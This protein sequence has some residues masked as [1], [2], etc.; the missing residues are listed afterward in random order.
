MPIKA[1]NA[2][3]AG[4]AASISAGIIWAADHGAKVIS[5]SAAT[6]SASTTLGAAV[7]Y[8]WSKGCVIV[9]AAGNDASTALQYPA[10]YP[11]VLSVAATDNTDTLLFYSEYGSWIKCAAPG[12]NV[13]STYY[14][15]SY[16]GMSGTSTAAPH[17]AA[18]AAALLSQNPLLSNAQVGTL[19]TSQVDPVTP[20]QGRGL[21][22]GVGRINVYRAILAAGTGQPTLT[23]VSF[24][25]ATIPNATNTLGTVFLG[26]PAPAGGVAVSLVSS[27][28]SVATVPASVTVP[29]GMNSVSFI[30]TGKLVASTSKTTVKATAAGLIAT[31]VLQVNG[32]V[33]ASLTISPTYVASKSSFTG[34]ITLDAPAPS[35][36][37]SVTLT[38]N[39]GSI[40]TTPTSVNVPAGA[41]SV[42][43]TGSTGLVSR[44]TSVSV[45][46]SRNGAIKTTTIIVNPP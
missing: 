2:S 30:A 18:E 19:I 31:T 43:F 25:P 5:I 21:A 34:T 46:A 39:G 1:L 14:A 17:V 45:T 40:V 20:Y 24:D 8:A 11:N 3:G 23:A 32:S 15:S 7:A 28:T 36:G 4:T 29:A 41:L 37:A 16:T 6:T 33:V 13:Y 27:N 44:R 35:G 12:A 22:V 26:G 42:K 10:A 38:D 9:A